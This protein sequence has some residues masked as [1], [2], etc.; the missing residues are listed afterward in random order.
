M[1]WNIEICYFPFKQYID[2]N[3]NQKNYKTKLK[4][5]NKLSY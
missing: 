2:G 3:T 5:E 1:V 4:N